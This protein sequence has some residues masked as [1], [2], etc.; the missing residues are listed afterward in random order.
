MIDVYAW[1][2]DWLERLDEQTAVWIIMIAVHTYLWEILYALLV[3]ILF[4]A[5][6]LSLSTASYRESDLA[7]ISSIHTCRLWSFEKL[8][9]TSIL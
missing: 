1:Q 7:T 5:T 6:S 3:G 8:H 2:I 4:V 9:I